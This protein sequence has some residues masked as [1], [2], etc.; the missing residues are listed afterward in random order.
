MKVAWARYPNKCPRSIDYLEDILRSVRTSL[1]MARV[2]LQDRG[3]PATNTFV[4]DMLY[5]FYLTFHEEV[6]GQGCWP[7]KFQMMMN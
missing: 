7:V 3:Q 5:F 4:S 1:G 6:K 2:H